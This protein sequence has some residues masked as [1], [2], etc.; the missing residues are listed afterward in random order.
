LQLSGD[1]DRVDVANPASF[2]FNSDFTW[3][4]R[5]KT[6][7]GSGALLSR[8]PLGTAWNQG[9][10]ALFIRSD[11]VQF[12]T[13]WVGNPRTNVRVDDDQWHQVIVTFVAE[14]D[15]FDV[16]VDPAPGE[17]EGDYGNS[18]EVDRFDEHTHLHNDG[19]AETGFSIGQANFSGGLSDLNTLVGLVDDVAIFDRALVGA[20]LDQLIED[21]PASL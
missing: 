14:T 10:K 11:D 21:G 6:G 12:D 8:N 13:G 3:H 17:T 19:Y 5:F 1:G 16:F 20:E 4:I 15:R 2:D 7:Q 9:S 18:H